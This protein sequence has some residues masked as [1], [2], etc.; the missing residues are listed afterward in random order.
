M[1]AQVANG[2][3][4]EFLV[5][6]RI[7]DCFG[8]PILENASFAAAGRA[9]TEMVTTMAK[10]QYDALNTR[11]DH[12]VTN[13]FP[14]LLPRDITQIVFNHDGAGASGDKSDLLLKSYS[15]PDCGMSIKH[16]SYE[17]S[18][19]RC[20]PDSLISTLTGLARVD[21]GYSAIWNDL[22]GHVD[23]IWR[24]YTD[25][26][27]LAR[28]VRDSEMMELTH[29][30]DRNPEAA[31]RQF[32]KIA[33]GSIDN[34]NFK[35]VF[36]Y[37]ANQARYDHTISKETHIR[38][39]KS[40]TPWERPKDNPNFMSKSFKVHVVKDDNS[41]EWVTVRYKNGDTYAV[42]NGKINSLKPSISK[43]PIK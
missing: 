9:S 41:E 37:F 39:I 38:E 20:T 12:V 5:A 25:R 26:S 43:K 15:Q 36:R 27:K 35:I 23:I 30:L 14:N 11:V 13:I 21:T 7:Q 33:Y 4:L 3:G 17:C 8:V 18:S 34:N 32:G 28:A 1:S 31:C 29:L 22:R 10:P 42:L 19:Y 16:N 6:N 40:I 2:K 24:N